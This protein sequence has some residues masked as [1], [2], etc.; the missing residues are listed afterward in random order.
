M[1]HQPLAYIAYKT[2]HEKN[3]GGKTV[4][5]RTFYTSKCLQTLKKLG[6]N[7]SG[8]TKNPKKRIALTNLNRGKIN[9]VRIKEMLTAK[10]DSQQMI[11][12]WA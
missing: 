10:L 2:E 1:K 9:W 5:Q 12:T 3:R 7:L 11:F 4:G 6:Q 8:A